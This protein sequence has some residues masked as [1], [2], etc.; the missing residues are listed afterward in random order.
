[1]ERLLLILLFMVLNIFCFSVNEVVFYHFI[2]SFYTSTHIYRRNLSKIIELDVKNV[3][4]RFIRA[5]EKNRI[6]EN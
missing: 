2:Y 3:K 5:R 1:M 4:Y 6:I